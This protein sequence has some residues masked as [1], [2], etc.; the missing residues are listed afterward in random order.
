MKRLINGKLYNTETATRIADWDNGR[1]RS[2]FHVVEKYLYL[3]KKGNWFIEYFGGVATQFAETT[4][5]SSSQGRGIEPITPEEA[6]EFLQKYNF[7]E[8]AEKYFPE[9]I[10]EA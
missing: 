10:E 1:N 4:G 2:D 8:L 3:T 6:F 9:T 7:I 5:N